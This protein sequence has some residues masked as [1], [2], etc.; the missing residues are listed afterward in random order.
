M[1][2]LQFFYLTVDEFSTKKMTSPQRLGEATSIFDLYLS[3]EAIL[4]LEVS[5]KI[6][7]A[8]GEPYETAIAKLNPHTMEPSQ[9]LA[10]LFDDI[11]T[12]YIVETISN[13]LDQFRKSV[14]LGLGDLYGYS[15][16]LC[17]R[18]QHNPSSSLL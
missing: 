6:V 3:A 18:T 5:A 12:P 16:L 4:N 9:E 15:Q 7:N 17:T 10:S 14:A 1:P 13:E 8:K 11:I 2:L